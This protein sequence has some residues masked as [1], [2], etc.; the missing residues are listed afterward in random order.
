MAGELKDPI[1]FEGVH[2]EDD[3]LLFGRFAWLYPITIQGH[4]FSVPEDNSV[5]RC[6]QYLEL[7]SAAVRLPWHRYCWNNRDGCCQ[8]Q[9]RAA[10]GATIRSARACVT[11]VRAG[12]LIERLPE[13]GVLC[14]ANP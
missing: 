13:G 14:L 1:P 6:L 12:M 4:V 11:A 10:P 5:L 8:F 7:K 3:I 2:S 9:Y